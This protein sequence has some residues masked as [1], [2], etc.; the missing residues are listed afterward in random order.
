MYSGLLRVPC[1]E[2]L[3]GLLFTLSS[4]LS[5]AVDAFM[6]H[7][8][9]VLVE[10][11]SSVVR[12]AN[13]LVVTGALK[14]VIKWTLAHAKFA[15]LGLRKKV[16][17]CLQVQCCLPTLLLHYARWHLWQFMQLPGNANQALH[18]GA[19]VA[20]HAVTRQ[21]LSSPCTNCLLQLWQHAERNQR[22]SARAAQA[23]AALIAA[24]QASPQVVLQAL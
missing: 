6:C 12:I 13:V 15:A 4:L 17:G 16:H 9:V 18:H 19:I 1:A 20:I 24:A 11:I 8:R 2:A 10:G 22:R 14:I 23:R 21:C 3:G 5:C 7:W